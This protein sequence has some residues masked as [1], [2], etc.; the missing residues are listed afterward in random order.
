MSEEK[1]IKSKQKLNVKL[2]IIIASIVTVLAIV[3]ALVLII[4]RDAKAE[5]VTKQLELGDKYLGELEYE[6]AIAAY[7]EAIEIDSKCED[8]Y[9][10]L[11]DVYI[12]MGE[13]D[14]AEE[15]LKEAGDELG[16]SAVKDKKEELDKKKAAKD[17]N[18]VV[19]EEETTAEI[20][21]ETTTE[22]PTTEVR[23]PETETTMQ[24]LETETHVSESTE[25]PA[26]AFEWATHINGYVE[27]LGLED[28][29]LTELVIPG[30]I[31]GYEVGT[32]SRN[33]FSNLNTLERVY[34]PNSVTKIG[35]HAFFFCSSLKSIEMP[36]DLKVIDSYTFFGCSSLTSIKIPAGVTD[37]YVWAFG[38][39]KSLSCIEI[40]PSV[41]YIGYSAFGGCSSLET[42][43]IPASVT[44]IDEEAFLG[45]K[46]LK[47]IHVEADSYAETW[48]KENGY[49][50]EYYTP[51]GTNVEPSASPSGSITFGSKS[52]NPTVGEEFNVA[53]Y[54]KGNVD[55]AAYTF[56]IQYDTHKV[57]YISGADACVGGRLSFAGYPNSNYKKIWLVFKAKEA[58]TFSLEV[59]NPYIGPVDSS[60][61]DILNLSEVGNPTITVQAATSSETSS[62]ACDLKSIWIAE[63]GFYGFSAS[64][65]EYNITVENNV[66]S[67]TVSAR[68]EDENAIVEISDTNLKVGSNTINITV[69][70]TTGETK[71]YTIN[72]TRK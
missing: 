58:G 12:E 48:A 21:T 52:Y 23:E 44:H 64:R 46:A 35:S 20:P 43:K 29:S 16:S 10:A 61:G 31:N 28:K 1:N 72:V 62:T 8:A 27:I 14:K 33:A 66:E 24:E 45:C 6:Q 63:T 55:I 51:T 34:I 57:E 67:L 22:E 53:L 39:C 47:I 36:N 69:K 59:T 40:P 5:E 13:F 65:T 19:K 30:E 4:P 70:A 49:A 7:L 25:T 18:V 11:A 9:F 56:N 38:E 2:L 42:I 71:V 54:I 26:S 37:I 50:V 68:A 60:Y 32:I 15:I 3:V 17:S 41:V